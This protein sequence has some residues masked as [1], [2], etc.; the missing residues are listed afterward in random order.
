MSIALTL[1][2]VLLQ[3]TDTEIVILGGSNHDEFLGC[4]SCSNSHPESVWNNVSRHGWGNGFGTWNPFGPHRNPYGMN[5][6]CNQYSQSPPILVDRQGN[7]Y[8]TLSV[9]AYARGSICGAAGNPQVCRALRV[10][11]A[12]S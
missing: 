10:M 7:L 9:N 8:G 6:A 5:S 4:L 12:R 2:M 3:A 11:C 1:A